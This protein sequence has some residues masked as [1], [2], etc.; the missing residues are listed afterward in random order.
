MYFGPT[1]EEEENSKREYEVLLLPQ[2]NQP[3]VVHL[4]PNDVS[5]YK[6]EYF[7][8]HNNNFLVYHKQSYGMDHVGIEI[9]RRNGAIHQILKL[10]LKGCYDHSYAKITLSPSGRYIFYVEEVDKKNPED[11]EPAGT[12]GKIV[13]LMMDKKTRNF[14]LELRETI[15]DFVARYNRTASSHNTYD[16]YSY[17]SLKFF[18]T[19]KMELLFINTSDKVLMYDDIKCQDE[20]DKKFGKSE[21]DKEQFKTMAD[22][23]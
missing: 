20:V 4:N 2:Y 19:D 18:L 12:V 14:T 11:L 10:K 16:Y 17:G 7:F 1:E 13:E 23:T 15:E 3:K 9:Y 21:Y 5:Y 8:Y 6:A 22:M